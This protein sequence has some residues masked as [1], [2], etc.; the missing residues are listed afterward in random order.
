L[1]FVVV[2]AEYRNP[3]GSFVSKDGK[4]KKT[5]HQRRPDPERPGQ[6]IWNVDGVPIVP[7]RLPELIEAT[8]NG[9]FV[10]I[11]EGEAKVDLL[12]SWNVPATCCAGGAGKWKSE[13]SAFLRGADVIILPD[14][15]EPGRKHRDVVAASLQGIAASVRVLELPGLGPKGDVK[16]W[17]TAG[18]TVEMLHD[19][20]EREAKPWAARSEA[21]S[22]ASESTKDGDEQKHVFNA[23]G[24]NQMTFD[25]IKYVVHGYIVE[26]LTLFAGKP[27]IGKSWL[28]LHAANAVAE[29]GLTLGN[30][31]CEE[32]DVLY[33]AL[34]DNPRR[35]QSRMTKLFGTQNWP[36]RLNFTCE[37]PRLTEGGLDFIKTWIESAKRPRLVII[38]TLAVVRPPNR[39]EQG[40]YDADYAAVKELRDVAL[41][42]GIAIVLVH[43]LRKAEADDPFDTFSG[44]LGLTGAPDTIMIL[45]RDQTRGTRLHAKGRDL[46]EIEKAIRFDAET[47]TWFVLGDAEAIQKSSERIAIVAALEEAGTEPLTPNQIAS[48]CGMK[49]VA[50]RKMMTRLLKDGVVKKASYGKYSLATVVTA[51]AAAEAAE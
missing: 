24:L 47:C 13:H 34:E 5:F 28:L 8:G 9:H 49:P 15:D 3:D 45:S 42:Y 11:A 36:A 27:K 2:R 31:Q 50:V 38:D 23:E 4:R 21:D 41:K 40:T 29:G 46:I 48:A 25:P 35:L 6:W 33:A 44:T 37:M 19:L 7:Y 12:R 20:I 14:N 51:A 1:L 30:V 26:G 32:G 39:K 43:H 17:A 22:K 18:G 16:D 10:V